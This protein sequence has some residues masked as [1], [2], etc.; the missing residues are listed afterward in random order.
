MSLPTDKPCTIT[1]DEAPARIDGNATIT[2]CN[3]PTQVVP[4]AGTLGP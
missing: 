2:G 3:V 1:G 4:D